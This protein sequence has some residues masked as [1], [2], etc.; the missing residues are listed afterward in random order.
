M[1]KNYVIPKAGMVINEDTI[2]LP[3][4][5]YF[6]E[7]EGITIGSSNITLE[8]N[9]AIFIGGKKK[10]KNKESQNKDE[11]SYGYSK[12]GKDDSLGFNGIAV[13]SKNTENV[14]IKNLGAK[15][16][17]IGLKLENCRN[18]TISNNDF[19]YNYHNP[20]HGWDE[21]EDLGG[22]VLDHTDHC[23]IENNK[24]M[25]VWNA[26]TIKNG[27]KNIVKNNQFSHTSNVGLRL[28]RSCENEFYQNDFS[29]GIRKEPYEV[30]A[31]DSSC[32]LIETGSNH[33]K[34]IKNDMRFGGD[35][36]FIRSLNGWMSTGNYFEENDTS[37]ANNNAIEAW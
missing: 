26:L 4:V 31:R 23:F 6:F 29:W 20:D 14:T 13:Y 8:G 27:N 32:V 25:N 2:F 22:I 35:G 9:G 3:G 18:F 33:N 15:N 1:D 7:E 30:H 37:F 21:H 12:L 11:F 19:S 36:L 24:A 17:E 16:F 5:Y 28:W 10:L 34:F